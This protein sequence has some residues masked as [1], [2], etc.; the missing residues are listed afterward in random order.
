MKNIKF[1]NYKCQ[2]FMNEHSDHRSLNWSLEINSGSTWIQPLAFG[3]TRR[4]GRQLYIHFSHCYDLLKSYF[5]DEKSVPRDLEWSS[6]SRLFSHLLH[7]GGITPTM[8]SE[9]SC[10]NIRSTRYKVNVIQLERL[11]RVR[12]CTV[13]N[14][15]PGGEG[16]EGLPYE[17]GG[18][19]RRLA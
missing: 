2:N 7:P 9:I 3:M 15:Y 13:S 16:G 14:Q 19:A 1:Y 17:R 12:N 18:D 8:Q 10:R 4:I 6:L 11:K 5:D